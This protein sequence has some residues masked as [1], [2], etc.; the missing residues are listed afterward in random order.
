MAESKQCPEGLRP[1]LDGRLVGENEEP[2]R[3]MAQL[4]NE[5]GRVN[6][7][8]S[9]RKISTD[10]AI[11]TLEVKMSELRNLRAQAAMFTKLGEPSS[12][13]RDNRIHPDDQTD[14]SDSEI[15]F[16]DDFTYLCK[17]IF[18]AGTDVER[19]KVYQRYE[20]N[21]L[22]KLLYENIEDLMDLLFVKGANELSYDIR[23]KLNE[24]IKN[25]GLNPVDWSPLKTGAKPFDVLQ[26][27]VKADG[28]NSIKELSPDLGKTI[29]DQAT[30]MMEQINPTPDN[31][32][33]AP[34]LKMMFPFTQELRAGSYDRVLASWSFS[35]RMLPIMTDE[36]IVNEV[37]P[38]LDRLLSHDGIAVIFPIGFRSDVIAGK[39]GV[40]TESRLHATLEE[41]KKKS[42]SLFE[43][44]FSDSHDPQTERFSIL[45]ISKG[46]VFKNDSNRGPLS[47]SSRSVK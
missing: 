14:K 23:M 42:H 11:A 41:Y 18:Y 16:D 27:F 3:G 24:A 19:M 25:T 32:D 2:R 10:E 12:P 28:L 15:F 31:V 7:D 1:I 43:W 5:V 13:F 21:V 36:Q 20:N 39:R 22:P 17:N 33:G 6:Y 26:E 35:T 38:E 46:K 34:T 45:V 47:M 4:L 37:W 30:K 9:D 29:D 8:F 40:C 44:E